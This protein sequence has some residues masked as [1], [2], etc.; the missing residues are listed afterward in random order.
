MT[1]LDRARGLL[2]DPDSLLS[3]RNGRKRPIVHPP[4]VCRLRALISV[5]RRA[6]GQIQNA[7][8]VQQSDGRLQLGS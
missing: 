3:S 7:T 8:N 5:I 4:V 2:D 6:G 1:P